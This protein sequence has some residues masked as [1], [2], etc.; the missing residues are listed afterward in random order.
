[1]K[2]EAVGYMRGRG[3]VETQT[4]A[5]ARAEWADV[6]AVIR[7]AVDELERQALASEDAME[8]VAR[9]VMRSQPRMYREVVVRWWRKQSGGRREPVLV[10]LDGGAGGRVKAVEVGRGVRLRRDRGFGLNADL[11]RE[12][13]NGYWA[14]AALR[15][16]VVEAARELRRVAGVGGKRRM[17]ALLR[18]AEVAEGLHGEAM[19]RLR[20][21][22]Y[23]FAG[24]GGGADGVVD[25]DVVEDWS[26]DV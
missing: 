26:D 7:G 19:Q 23:E 18:W 14:V 8:A 22:G 25:E 6:F 15:A 3:G 24:G 13:V 4:A 2:R 17:A 11:A 10:R 5:D 12:A 20:D 16:E 1:M 21:V 9:A